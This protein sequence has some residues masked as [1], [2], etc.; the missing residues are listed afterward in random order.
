MC[1]IPE[2]AGPVK[3]VVG[4]GVRFSSSFRA[5][6]IGGSPEGGC[7]SRTTASV[8]LRGEGSTDRVPPSREADDLVAG[9][10]VRVGRGLSGRG[11]G[12]LWEREHAAGAGAQLANLV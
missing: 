3:S 6:V 12:W 4:R 1:V 2:R 5:G 9:G 11:V 10:S 8:Y 7:R